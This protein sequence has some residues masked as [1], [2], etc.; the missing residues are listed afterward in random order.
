V[1]LFILK[2]HNQETKIKGYINIV[3]FRIVAD[4]NIDPGRYGF[5]LVHESDRPH[6]FSSDGQMAVREWMK[7]L[8]KAT[9]ERD[10]GSMYPLA[11]L[12]LLTS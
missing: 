8:M 2:R 11:A 5:K 6:F 7:A 10:Y 3:G 9:I 4:E 12:L 1:W